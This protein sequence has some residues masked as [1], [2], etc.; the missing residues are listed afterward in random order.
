[1]SSTLTRDTLETS[2]FLLLATCYLLLATPAQAQEFTFSRAL[3]DYTYTFDQYRLS[4]RQYQ[5]KKNEYLKFGTLTSQTEAQ[6]AT[7][8]MLLKRDD[9]IR[10]YLTALRLKLA[11]TPGTDPLDR[12][13]LF[14][15]IDQEVN[16]LFQHQTKLQNTTSLAELS[17]VSQ[18]LQTR[19]TTIQLLAYQSLTSI[20]AGKQNGLRS[21]L[22]THLQT[23]KSS[24]DQIRQ[25]GEST[26]L[27]DRWLVQ[28]Q[29]RLELSLERQTAGEFTSQKLTP[30]NR[31]LVQEF[32]NIEFT[33]K[34]SHQYLKET[35]F[36]L[37][38]IIK[39]IIT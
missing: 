35:L 18:E 24:V 7:L 10:T 14:A 23:L 19:Y 28:A 34:E 20:L 30:Q 12:E 31:N 16:W 15:R 27:L 8:D 3:N 5:L 33:L 32:L 39:E 13:A 22:Q 37:Q 11:E 38:E 26:Q 25:S 1:M 29:Q 2:F 17:R 4:H 21:Q 9:V 6:T 36:S